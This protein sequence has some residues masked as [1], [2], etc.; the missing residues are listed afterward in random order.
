MTGSPH[1][2][3]FGE[4]WGET[5]LLAVTLFLLSLDWVTKKSL[6]GQQ[7]GIGYTPHKV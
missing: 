6:A 7:Q 3:I 2:T 1:G 4:L 5:R